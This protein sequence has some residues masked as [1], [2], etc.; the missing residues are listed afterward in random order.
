MS[1]AGHRERPVGCI[2]SRLAVASTRRANGAKANAARAL[3]RAAFFSLPSPAVHLPAQRMTMCVSE[4][5]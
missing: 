2:R 1:E 3:P 5:R 4:I